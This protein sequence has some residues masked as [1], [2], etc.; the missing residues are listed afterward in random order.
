M[1]KIEDFRV[2][3]SKVEKGYLCANVYGNGSWFN[4]I[5]GQHDH[6]Y[7]IAVP[8]WGHCC[9]LEGIYD[10]MYNES[11]ILEKFVACEADVLCEALGELEEYYKGNCR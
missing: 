4:C 10:S 8:N 1:R 11:H 6:G 9:E 5:I 3:I 2:K 7:F